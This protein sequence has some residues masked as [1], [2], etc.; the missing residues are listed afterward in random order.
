MIYKTSLRGIHKLRWQD[1]E[2]F[3]PPSPLCWQIYYIS[4]CSIVDIWLTPPLPL[5]CQRSL[6][7]STFSEKTCRTL[8]AVH[9]S[10]CPP[11]KSLDVT[12][13][14]TKISH[15]LYDVIT[16]DS[17]LKVT[18]NFIQICPSKVNIWFWSVTFEVIAVQSL[19]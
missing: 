16:F 12:M 9:I 8:L 4:L 19:E 18:F 15:H 5:A 14:L 2:D 10:K 17:I 13:D 11:P 1:F 3:W 7:T 6:W